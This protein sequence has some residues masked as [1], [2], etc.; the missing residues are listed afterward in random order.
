MQ[1]LTP[2]LSRIRFGAAAFV[3]ALMALAAA[4]CD[5]EASPTTPMPAPAPAPAPAPMPELAPDPIGADEVVDRETLKAF[6]EAAAQE[7]AA[8]IASD[9]DAY[10]FLDATFGP[11]GRWRQGEV[12]VFVHH[13]DGTGFFHPVTKE[14][15]GQNLLGLEDVNGVKI[16]EEYLAAVA[17][18]GGYVEYRWPNPEVEGDEETGSPK[19]GYA[20][21]LDIGDLE[22]LVGAGFY[23]PV[24]AADVLNRGNLQQFV[25][26]A[27]AALS[28]HTADRETAHAFLDSNF[29]DEGEWRHEDIYVFVL[30]MEGINFFQAPDPDWEGTDVSEQEDLNGV[31]LGQGLLEAA[32]A[33]GGFVE[34][35]W[36]NPAVEGDEE[37]GSPKLAYAVPITVGEEPMLLGSGIYVDTS[38]Q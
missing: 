13:R 12:Y 24:T 5:D 23:P 32:R 31:R 8:G 21:P 2:S 28:E 33:G 26:R 17:A 15:E 14:L 29:R 30:T 22:L 36:D 1:N 19:V 11:E 18:G 38:E 27:A 37:D 7:A 34:Y 9:A 6:V 4:A 16:S 25:E 3:V 10:A 20:V 35:N